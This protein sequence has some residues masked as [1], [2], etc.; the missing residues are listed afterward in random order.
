MKVA[1]KKIAA[2]KAVKKAVKKAAAGPSGG[3]FPRPPGGCPQGSKPI[4]Y[5]GTKMCQWL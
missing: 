5:G 1:K 4:D 2:K 3:I